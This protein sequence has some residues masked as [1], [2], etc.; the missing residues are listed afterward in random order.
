MPG[1]SPATTTAPSPHSGRERAREPC[2]G[3]HHHR[4]PGK[5]P[6]QIGG[7]G[8][9]AQEPGIG[10]D[11]AGGRQHVGQKRLGKARRELPE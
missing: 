10:I 3:L 2:S 11:G 9:R 6:A 5:A 1:A 7:V 8:G 4:H